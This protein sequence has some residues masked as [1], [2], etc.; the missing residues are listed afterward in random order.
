[1]KS[2][3][4]ALLLGLCLTG[5]AQEFPKTSP[6]TKLNEIQILGTHNSY[7]QSVDP[8]L[9]EYVEPILARLTAERA[10]RMTSEQVLSYEEEHPNRVTFTEALS[11]R[12][13]DLK[14]Q[15]NAGMRGL[16]LDLNPDPQGGLFL[17]PAGYRF[18]RSKGASDLAPADQTGLDQP[19]LKVLHIADLDFRSHCPTF[20]G[21]LTQIREW[22][23]ANPKHV[24]L[25]ILLEAK[26]QA[27]PIF[28]NPTQLAPFDKQAFDRIDEEI[29]SVFRR[30]RLIVPDDVRG[31]HETLKKAVLAQNWPSLEQSRGKV[32]FLM[33]TANGTASTAPYLEGHPSLK[34]RVAFLRASPQDDH[35]A[36]LMFDN[37][38]LR[39]QE[40]QGYVQSGYLV[41]T[42]ADIETL[43]AKTNDK[44]R[45]NAAF[46]SGAQIVSTDFFRPGNVYGTSYVVL[47]PDGGVARCNPVLKRA[48]STK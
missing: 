4:P 27:L 6:Q 40:I 14:T 23:D 35:A 20:K 48:C 45:A 46:A 21:C 2:L 42:R 8:Q 43:E 12:H 15:L 25:F 5:T 36:F 19:G 7:A 37:A 29:L 30:E 22:S 44:S 13:P 47:L 38:I 11:Y 31:S 34:G 17:N 9:M 10:K 33:I 24:P 39:G 18:L 16:E 1:M 32:L 3:K 28:P 26:S 41:R